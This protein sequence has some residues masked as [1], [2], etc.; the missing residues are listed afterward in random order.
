MKFPLW[1]TPQIYTLRSIS[2]PPRIDLA[3]CKY[4]LYFDSSSPWRKETENPRPGLIEFSFSFQLPLTSPLMSQQK[5]QSW[6]PPSAPKSS[7]PQCPNPSLTTCFAPC[8]DPYSGGCN[9]GSQKPR[10]QSPGCSQRAHHK[11]PC[12]L[13]GGTVYH[14]KEEEC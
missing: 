2:V 9:S 12:C 6:K 3:D 13:S 4:Q 11:K 1:F 14:I 7:P 10:E 8:C 5:Q